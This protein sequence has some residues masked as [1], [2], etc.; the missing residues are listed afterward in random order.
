VPSDE[1]GAAILT[2]QQLHHPFLDAGDIDP[3]QP[4]AVEN[5]RASINTGVE[6]KGHHVVRT[7]SGSNPIAPHNASDIMIEFG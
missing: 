3:R 1:S 6:L 7:L 4:V 2:Q 5:D